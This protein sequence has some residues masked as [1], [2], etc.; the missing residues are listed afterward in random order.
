MDYIVDNA[1]ALSAI[2]LGVLVLAGLAIAG[3]AGFR[4]WR[5]VRAAQRRASAAAAELAAESDRLTASLAQL[6]ERQAELQASIAALQRRAAAASVLAGSASEALDV[7][8]APLRYLG[9]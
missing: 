9:R 7:L 6:P 8:R 2:T 3:I 4:L 1:V 5:A